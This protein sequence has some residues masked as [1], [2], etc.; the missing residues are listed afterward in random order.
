MVSEILVSRELKDFG[1]FVVILYTV[2]TT[3]SVQNTTLSAIFQF[4][5]HGI[6]EAI[7]LKV[8]HRL[9]PIIVGIEVSTGPLPNG[10]PRQ[11]GRLWI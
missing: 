1:H 8:L 2:Y 9:S 11:V 5:T 7:T 4:P 6:K 3:S 10:A